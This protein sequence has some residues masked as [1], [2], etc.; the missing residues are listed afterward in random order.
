MPTL[1]CAQ[2]GLQNGQVISALAPT[3][4]SVL[5]L[6]LKIRPST[7]AFLPYPSQDRGALFLLYPR[8]SGRE[9]MGANSMA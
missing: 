2:L 6:S 8:G 5:Q 9:N 1:K 3:F 4:G 7:V